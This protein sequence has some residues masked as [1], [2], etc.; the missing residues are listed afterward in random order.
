MSGY[1]AGFGDLIAWAR[2]HQFHFDHDQN[3]FLGYWGTAVDTLPNGFNW[4]PYW[5]NSST[6]I[7]GQFAHEL[8]KIVHFHGPKFSTARCF[9]DELDKDTRSGVE[10]PSIDRIRNVDSIMLPTK[11]S[12]GCKVWPIFFLHLT[13]KMEDTSIKSFWDRLRV[14]YIL[15]TKRRRLPYS[16]MSCQG[17][18]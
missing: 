2:H 17:R 14:I 10:S 13:L 1:T 11:T 16:L 4:K 18:A 15:P 12:S 8:I 5:G 9:L 3:L 6:A 7:P